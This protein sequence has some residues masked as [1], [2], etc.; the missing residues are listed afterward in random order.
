MKDIKT[1]VGE[2]C[3]LPFFLEQTARPLRLF[4]CLYFGVHCNLTGQILFDNFTDRMQCG[5]MNFL[6]MRCRIRFGRK[7]QI[8]D[9]L[10]GTFIA[11]QR[12]G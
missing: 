6:D 4:E 1:A 7:I 5:E 9:I 2:D 3:F 12:N 10:Q 11:G 8:A